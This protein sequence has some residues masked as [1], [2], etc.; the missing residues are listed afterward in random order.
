MRISVSNL[1][2]GRFEDQFLELIDHCHTTLHLGLLDFVDNY[3]NIMTSH[4]WQHASS[5]HRLVDHG[6]LLLSP[7]NI[8]IWCETQ[9]KTMKNKRQEHVHFAPRNKSSRAIGGPAPERAPVC[10]T[11]KMLV[12]P[13]S[14][15][16]EVIG[17][18]TKNLGVKMAGPVGHENCM[19]R[20]EGLPADGNPLLHN[21]D[22]ERGGCKA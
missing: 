10:T 22:T 3:Q 13:E 19:S 17:I 21:T 6:K 4:R 1:K 16:I 5:W 9:I 14:V 18:R 11:P 12:V 15:R 8:L 7:T 2:S 20:I